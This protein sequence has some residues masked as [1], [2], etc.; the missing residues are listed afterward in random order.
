MPKQHK[1]QYPNTFYRVSL[2][3]VI[4]DKQGRVLVNKEQDS[5]TWNLPGGGLDHDE[6]MKECLSRELHEEVSYVGD[7]DMKLF[8]TAVFWLKSK[9]AWLLWIVYDVKPE[10]LGFS[11]GS[12]STKVG[13]ISPKQFQYSQN[14]EEKWIYENL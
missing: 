11:V 12:D 14:F 10:N 3:A 9:Q 8:A 4:R 1:S 2:K 5:T 13:F 6:T 7:F